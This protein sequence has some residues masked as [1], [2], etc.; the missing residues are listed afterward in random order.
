MR[1][2]SVVI[3]AQAG[4]QIAPAGAKIPDSGSPFRYGRN[5]TGDISSIAARRTT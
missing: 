4:I 5:D 2:S 3:P 1:T